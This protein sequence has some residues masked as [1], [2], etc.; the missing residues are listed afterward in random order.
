MCVGSCTLANGV[1][2]LCEKAI[3]SAVM[4]E[5]KL[6]QDHQKLTLSLRS[7]SI[8]VMLHPEMT[9]SD[10]CQPPPPYWQGM[11]E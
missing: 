2:Y 4:T 1:E 3:L 5:S 9:S 10:G 6:S 8:V 11:R 7:L